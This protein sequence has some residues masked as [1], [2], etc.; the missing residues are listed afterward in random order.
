MNHD[1]AANLPRPL[2]EPAVHFDYDAVE[3]PVDI[4][5]EDLASAGLVL[6]AAQAAL[7]HAWSLRQTDTVA[8]HELTLAE[9]VI[10]WIAS[11]REL[12]YRPAGK[13]SRRA[14][15]T[16][17]QVAT[18]RLGLRAAVAVKEMTPHMRHAMSV[19]QIATLWGVSRGEVWMLQK[20][21][22][23]LV[24]RAAAPLAH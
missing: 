8:A 23:A 15:E 3:N 5:R 19:R 9:R 22:R 13:A 11:G 6:S 24:P 4:V 17:Q 1:P 7:V 10:G 12:D 21:F 14:A 20:N 2:R 18:R 16:A